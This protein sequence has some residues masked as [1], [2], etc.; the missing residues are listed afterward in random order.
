[1]FPGLNATFIALV[2]KGE[3]SNKP[4]KYRPIALCNMIYK[5]ISK[6]IA[7]RLKPLL[8]LIISPEQSGYVEGRQITDGIILTHE[9]IHSLKV[10]KKPG[11]LLKLD[12]SKA[13]DSLSWVYIHKILTTFG[14]APS[15]IRWIYSLIS[16][17]FFSVLING[18]PSATFRPSRGIR[19][20]DPLS[21]FLFVI[22]AEGLGRSI[23]AAK[24][25]RRLRGL[26]F[27]NSPVHTHQQF[28][29]D[30]MLF[31]HPSVQEARLIK[32]LL[33]TFSDASGALINRV[34]S[35]IFFFNTPVTTQRAIER[36]LGF[37]STSLPSKYLGAPLTSSALK[38]SS[39][40][41]LLEKLE[42][43]LFLWT[44]RSLNMAGRVILIKV[45]LQSMPLYL[46]SIL[47]APKW[48]L[49]EIK[50]LQRRFLWG[51]SG[52]N[53]KWALLKWEKVC[54]PK[55][56]G[57]IGL[58][59]PE[60]SNKAMGAKIWWRWLVH[61]RTPWASLWT[62]KY[63]SNYPME[64][65][66]RMTETSS[67]SAIWNAAIQNRF[68]IQEH[69]FWEIKN[70]SIAR[71]WE[72][73]W[74]QMPK[75]KDIL[76]D[77]PD[78]AR[79]IHHQAKVNHC[80]TPE[81][82]QDYRKWKDIHLLLPN[83]SE[84]TYHL[85]E[86]ELQKRQIRVS[87]E[88]DILRWGHE[89]KG[90]FTT[91]EAYN[92]IIQEQIHKDGMWE[93]VW[94]KFTWPKVSTFLWILCHNRVLTWDNLRKRSFSGPSIS[95]MCRQ[96]EETTIHLMQNCVMGKKLW[97]R[98]AFRCQK[99]RRVQDDIRGTI[100]NGSQA[101]FQSPILNELWTLLPGFLMWNLWKERNRRIFKDQMLPME[102]LWNI[103]HQ[104]I[105]ET[106][107]LKEWHPE[108][109]PTLPQEKV[110]WDNWQISINHYSAKDR[111]PN[112]HRQ[113]AS[114]WNPPPTGMIQLNF[115]GASKGNPGQAGY[116]GVFRDH[117]GHPLSIF[118]GS[119]GWDTNNSAELEGLWRG[120]KIAHRKNFFPLIVEGD[121][122]II[123]RM[124]TKLQY[125]SP[126]HKISSSWRMSQRL[127][128]INHWL[129]MHQAI[130]F[131]HIRWEGN[132]LADLL[133]NL[134]VEAKENHFEG[135]IDNLP[136]RDQLDTLKAM[137]SKE[138]SLIQNSHPDAGVNTSQ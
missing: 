84:Q 128:M 106:L 125:G 46:F 135:A 119:I 57:C 103:V 76:Q 18:I 61:P 96:E 6:V 116:G 107:S 82:P 22:M 53:Q 30:N 25:N 28:V 60:H 62:A 91:K 97:E 69:S 35:Q 47:A 121:S 1:M 86:T 89:E 45:V 24:I 12:L 40:K 39:W 111:T 108:D 112:K 92:I 43:H 127:E 120:L 74:Q 73:S 133:A 105:M 104:N 41:H 109:L 50:N 68:L 137:I 33:S 90:I 126:I 132:K 55:Y 34:K 13:F 72:D 4:D 110:V 102:K 42:D 71:F 123:I 101:P 59:D 136:S 113:E 100:D 118:M 99:E 37:T 81:V 131:K 75:I 11:M 80:W 79:G 9:L 58:R 7:N 138:I 63:A 36:I 70:G 20:G 27:H 77:L 8:P 14:F 78:N 88:Q 56:V 31:A 93:K 85:L 95:Y 17:A 51:G 16:S 15:W 29:D 54:L 98:I 124:A 5:I 83:S 49:K 129:S 52:Q 38:H 3:D 94:H 19:Q 23:T 48:V 2:P 130:T 44:N 67:G 32:S 134:G 26:S 21:P 87:D 114:S 66:L 122:Q 10:T 64:E 115:D 117:H 65:R